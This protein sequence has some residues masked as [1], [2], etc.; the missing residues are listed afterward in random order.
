MNA[1]VLLNSVNELRKSEKMRG[2]HFILFLAV[3]SMYIKTN[4][5]DINH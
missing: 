5:S 4:K 3:K 1:H 2:L